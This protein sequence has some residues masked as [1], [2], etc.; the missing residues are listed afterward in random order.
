MQRNT[1]K[2]VFIHVSLLGILLFSQNCTEGFQVDNNQTLE[3]LNNSV[4]TAVCT[5]GSTQTGYIM[6]TALQP[7]LCGSLI[8]KNCIDGQW[9]RTEELVPTC[10]QLCRHPVTNEAAAPGITLTSYSVAQAATQ[11]L[12]NAARV[13]STC[14]QLSG[15]FTP[16]LGL[17]SACLVQGQVCAYANGPGLSVPT[18]NMTGA[19]VAGFTAQSATSP[20]L[21]GSQVT[22]TCQATGL[23][24]GSTPLYTTCEQRCLHPDSSQPVTQNTVYTYFTRSSGS[25]TECN[26][27]RVNSTCQA[28]SGL[29]S[30]VVAQTRY[31]SCAVVAPPPPPPPPPSTGGYDLSAAVARVPF[32]VQLPANPV[33]TSEVICR[34]EAEILASLAVNGRR[35]I[36]APGDYR[37]ESITV[38]GNNKHIVF[39]AGA[40][41]SLSAFSVFNAQ[42]IWIEGANLTTTGP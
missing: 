29:F 16:A 15:L 20:T 12:C 8:T 37:F 22:R 1:V 39:Q 25:Q 38:G 36:I 10:Q 23:W 28:S 5:S 24:S 40:R 7:Q 27:A 18:G 6:S 32:N 3:S 41:M 14:N 42:R 19:T 21:C 4:N 34:T 13:Q 26:A 9:D 17:H 35:T 33:I 30:P 11:E 2:K 31:Q